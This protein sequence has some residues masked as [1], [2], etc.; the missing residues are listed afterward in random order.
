[1]WTVKIVPFLNKWGL[2][3]LL[4]PI[5][6]LQNRLL[7]LKVIFSSVSW[8]SSSPTKPFFGYYCPLSLLVLIS[9]PLFL[10]RYAFLPLLT[11]FSFVPIVLGFELFPVAVFSSSHSFVLLATLDP[12]EVPLGFHFIRLC[13][14]LKVPQCSLDFS[15][16]SCDLSFLNFIFLAPL[17][18]E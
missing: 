11:L 12:T 2:G 5:W 8:H 9:S 18:R 1:M 10:S 4:P 6:N 14:F 16:I 17:S 3:K 7:P 13:Y 15:P